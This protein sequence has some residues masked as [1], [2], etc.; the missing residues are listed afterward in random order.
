MGKL[1]VFPD[2]DQP[3]A[4]WCHLPNSSNPLFW[5][6]INHVN[7]NTDYIVQPYHIDLYPIQ[8]AYPQQMPTNHYFAFDVSKR[9]LIH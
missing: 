8:H 1:V 3:C 9:L 4:G 5:S 2:N 6:L 7:S